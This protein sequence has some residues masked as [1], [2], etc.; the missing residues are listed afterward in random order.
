[1]KLLK[2]V[3][4]FIILIQCITFAQKPADKAQPQLSIQQSNFVEFKN[5]VIAAS[6]GAITFDGQFIVLGDAIYGHFDI[7]AYNTSDK[8]IQKARSEDRAWKR[9]HGGN[10]KSITL[11][12][13]ASNAAKVVVSFHEMRINPNS[14]ACKQ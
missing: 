5:S 6:N 10:L 4:S 14:G 2:K 1:M 11:S 9:D 3:L 7:V 12:I 13:S 8:V